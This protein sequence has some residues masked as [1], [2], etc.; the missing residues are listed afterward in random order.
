MNKFEFS[1][2]GGISSSDKIC[3]KKCEVIFNSF[4]QDFLQSFEFDMNCIF[5]HKEAFNAFKSD[6][7]QNLSNLI[8]DM[9]KQ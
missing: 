9:A 1:L 3:F 6:I 4:Y 7:Q 5:F 2:P 8:I